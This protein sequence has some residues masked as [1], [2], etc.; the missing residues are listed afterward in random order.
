MRA[1][2]IRVAHRTLFVASISS[3]FI[4][5]RAQKPPPQDVNNF[6]IAPPKRD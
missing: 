4:W 6:P 2:W 1:T 5:C 3:T